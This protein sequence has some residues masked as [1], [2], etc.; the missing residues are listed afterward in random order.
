MRFPALDEANERVADLTKER[1]ELLTRARAML[2][3]AEAQRRDLTE[4]ERSEHEG[5]LAGIERLNTELDEAKAKQAKCERLAETIRSGNYGTERVGDEPRSVAAGGTLHDQARRTIEQ[6][7]RRQ[8]LPDY[9]AER[10][11]TLVTTGTADQQNT[12]ARWAVATGNPAYLRAFCK[13]LGDPQRGHMLWDGEEQ[14]A[15][16]AVEQVKT[17]MRAMSLTDSAGGFMVPLTLDPAI[18]LTSNGSINPLR[19]ISRV[20]QTA[21][22]AW[23][24]VTSAGVTAEWKAEAA[25]VADVTPT[26]DDAPIPVHFGDAY[27]QYS[28][29][30]GMDAVNFARE[31]QGVLMDA[32]DQLMATAYTTGSGSGQPRGI[33]TALDGTA[34]ELTPTTAEAFAAADVYKVQNALGPRFQARAQWAANLAIINQAAQFETTNGSKM[35]PE[36]GNNP[37]VLLR[38]PMNELSNMDGAIDPAATADNFVLLYGDFQQ[39]VIVDRIGTQLELIPNVMGANRRPTG[40]RGALLWFRT[41]SDVVIPNAFRTLNVATTA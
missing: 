10:A 9:A 28:F 14:A 23:Q 12:A 18:M 41:G 4:A 33:I 38:K 35:F 11:E 15:Y 39:F 37:P 17:S 21:T 34:S 29:E 8:E 5:V 6:A 13:L 7:H 32:A 40:Q 30:V 25:E 1:E 19:Q 26:L 16:T 22:D 3:G 24:G 27:V 31:L 20:V 36:L 2:D